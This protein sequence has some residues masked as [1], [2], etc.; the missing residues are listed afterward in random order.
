MT[1][2]LIANQVIYGRSASTG[3]GSDDTDKLP[4]A[5]RAHFNQK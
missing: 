1:S 2:V 5:G 4:G 3:A